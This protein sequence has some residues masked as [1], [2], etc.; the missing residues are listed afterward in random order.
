MADVEVFPLAVNRELPD[1]KE[2]NSRTLPMRSRSRISA[3]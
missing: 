1:W 3:T 2:K